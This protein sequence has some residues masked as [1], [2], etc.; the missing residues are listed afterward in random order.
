MYMHEPGEVSDTVE[1]LTFGLRAALTISAI[2][3]FVLGILPNAVVAFAQH[4][5][6]FV[7]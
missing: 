4:S 5:A 1:P 6:T 7:R 3:I 2:G